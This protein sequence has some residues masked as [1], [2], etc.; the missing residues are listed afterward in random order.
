MRELTDGDL[1]NTA[2]S[3][4]S[5]NGYDLNGMTWNPEYKAMKIEYNR[6]GYTMRLDVYGLPDDIPLNVFSELLVHLI[7]TQLNGQKKTAL[8][9]NAMN[10]LSQQRAM[11]KKKA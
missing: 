7:R 1:Y 3:V 5:D 8:D 9:N 10:W 11:R 4:L 2:S 6:T